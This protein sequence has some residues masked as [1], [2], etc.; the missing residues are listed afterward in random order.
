VYAVKSRTFR[1]VRNGAPLERALGLV[2]HP[3]HWIPESSQRATLAGP[4][5]FCRRRLGDAPTVQRTRVTFRGVIRSHNRL[6]LHKRYFKRIPSLT[7]VPRC[8]FLHNVKVT[9]TLRIPPREAISL[10]RKGIL[11]KLHVASLP[12]CARAKSVHL[13]SLRIGL[14]KPHKNAW[15]RP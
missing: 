14:V 8:I 3:A 5:T 1:A 15:L 10:A 9:I 7:K 13:V 2:R 11:T 4:N 12:D 6:I